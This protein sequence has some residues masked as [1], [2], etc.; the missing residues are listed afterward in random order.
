MTVSVTGQDASYLYYTCGEPD[1]E[2]RRIRLD[3]RT[4][5]AASSTA[6]LLDDG[7]LRCAYHPNMPTRLRCNKCGKPVCTRCVVTTAVGQRC[8]DCARA[9]P[10]VTY[11]IDAS[12]LV[13][14]LGAGLVAALVVGGAWG[15]WI[16]AGLRRSPY[17]WSFWFALLLGFGV[18]ETVS[19]AANRKR[20]VNLQLVAM[21][22]VLLGVLVSRLVLNARLGGLAT[23]DLFLN[24]PLDVLG[25]LRLGLLQLLFVVLACAIPYVRFR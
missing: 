13:R 2:P 4:P 16:D 7:E 20:G 25:D 5:I 14:A 3:W 8:R 9:R 6:P 10:I 19:W 12:I 15:L 21:G 24:R 23:L 17:D 11:E 1:R 18:A 22:C